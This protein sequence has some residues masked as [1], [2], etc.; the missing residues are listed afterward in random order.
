[1][2][3]AVDAVSC[4]ERCERRLAI[5]LPRRLLLRHVRC[6]LLLRHSGRCLRH[7]GL[8]SL[9][10]DPSVQCRSRLVAACW[11]VA[12]AF[13]P[14]AAGAP[15]PAQV[16]SVVLFAC[17]GAG[18][19]CGPIGARAGVRIAILMCANVFTV[20]LMLLVD[21]FCR[22]CRVMRR[23]PP[24]CAQPPPPPAPPRAPQVVSPQGLPLPPTPRPLP[25]PP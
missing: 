12:T 23:A 22:G 15:A 21:V 4:G 3:S 5:C 20:I 10:L 16:S 25:F 2:F 6:E 18:V 1:M 19:Q 11:V 14:A 7:P 8:G 24:P 13:A 17:R 9:R